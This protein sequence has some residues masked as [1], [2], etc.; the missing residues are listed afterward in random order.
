MVRD[1]LVKAKQADLFDRQMKFAP[2]R[3][4][5]GGTGSHAS[6]TRPLDRKRPVHLV[7]K[8]SC[9][10]GRLSL[11]SHRTTV[12]RIIAEWARRFGVKVRRKENMRNHLHI[13][14]TFSRRSEFQNFL[15]TIT[16]LIARAVTGARKGKPFGQKFWY[17]LAYTRIVTGIRDLRAL[18]KY[19]DKNQVE[20]EWGADARNA[21]EER[22]RSERKLRRRLK[23]ATS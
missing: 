3:I 19:F 21:I 23:S 12:D 5:H 11:L 4:R 14:A 1:Q 15:R 8:A 7:L 9:A 22:E 10:T 6:F 2:R 13:Y 18:Q 16:S 20:R 17:H